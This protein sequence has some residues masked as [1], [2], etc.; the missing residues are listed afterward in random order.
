MR[1]PEEVLDENREQRGE[2]IQNLSPSLFIPEPEEVKVSVPFEGEGQILIN[3]KSSVKIEPIPK[4]VRCIIWQ[5]FDFKTLLS[6][7]C[8]LS[9]ADK[10]ALLKHHKILEQDL[11]LEL[12][13]H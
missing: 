4:N 1:I 8:L 12:D 13:L 10:E 2:E 6:K 11:H 3:N 7:I 9:K 5:F